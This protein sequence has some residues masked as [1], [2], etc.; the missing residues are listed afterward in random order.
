VRTDGQEAQIP[1]SRPWLTDADRRAVDAT[2]GSLMIAEGD[3]SRKLELA[4]AEY[5]GQA[6]GVATPD[7]TTA[8]YVA[9]LA[10]GVGPSDDVAIPTYVC[11]AVEQAVRWTGATPVLCDVGDDWCVDA[12]SV[13]H[14]LTK[15]TKAVIVVHTFGIVAE[16]RPIVDLGVPVIEDLAQAFGASSPDGRAGTFGDLSIA[17][18]HA[19]KCLT[20]GEGGMAFTRDERLL[21]RLH[22][23]KRSAHRLPLSNLQAALGLSQLHRYDEFLAHR[24]RI[25]E[26][27]RQVIPD[28]FIPPKAVLDR[29]MNFRFPVLVDRD[30]E[31][32]MTE[33]ATHGV[34]AKRGVDALLH[35]KDGEFPGAESAYKRT[36]SLPIHPSMSSEEVDRVMD[37]FQ[38]VLC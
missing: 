37:A 2:L 20:T 38:Q 16:M 22:A 23:L 24:A 4:A 35:K 29:T 34:L 8:L 13:K 6:G 14:V 30:V 11:E 17:S 9:L 1:H 32:L 19:T 33:F 28:R 27:Y 15:R 21:G 18:F 7:G 26:R 12:D 5:L 3:T 25:A 36:L 31:G 10:L